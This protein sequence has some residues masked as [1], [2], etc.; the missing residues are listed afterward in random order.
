MTGFQA[1]LLNIYIR[2]KVMSGVFMPDKSLQM[3]ARAAAEL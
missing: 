3:T 1:E 2:H